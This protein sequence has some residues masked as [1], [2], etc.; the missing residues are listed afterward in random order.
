MTASGLSLV[1]RL[2]TISEGRPGTQNTPPQ[3]DLWEFGV[4]IKSKSKKKKAVEYYIKVQLGTPDSNVICISFHPAEF[5]INYPKL[6][7]YE[8]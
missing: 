7:P 2:P 8:A 4:L 3:G 1:L 6:G 5:K